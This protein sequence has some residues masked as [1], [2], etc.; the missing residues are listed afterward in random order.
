MSKN[1]L[2]P[3][4]KWTVQHER[5]VAMHIGGM[6]V[7]SIAKATKMTQPRISQIID[8][9]QARRIINEA[10]KQVRS[11]MMEN[12]DDGLA[13][14]AITA[15]KRIAETIN[16]PDF[17]LGSDAKKHQDR[18]SLDLAKLVYSNNSS[19]VEAVPPLNEDLSRRLIEALEDS[20][21]AD[22][23]IQDGKF[24]VVKEQDRRTEGVPHGG[25]GVS[26]N[27]NS[28]ADDE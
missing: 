4:A 22:E 12:L 24:E 8:D 16:F 27:L 6:P 19:T 2:A 1:A 13:A 21:A 3:I 26:A 5:I 25:L 23:L 7:G 10:M 20:K 17:V 15:M 28:S 18:L 14:L 11:Q 9:P